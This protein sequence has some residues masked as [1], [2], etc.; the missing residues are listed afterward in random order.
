MEFKRLE[1]SVD[2]ASK[3][4]I[5]TIVGKANTRKRRSTYEEFVEDALGMDIRQRMCFFSYKANAFFADVID[6]LEFLLESANVYFKDLSSGVNEVDSHFK[7]SVN[8]SSSPGRKIQT[9]FREMMDPLKDNYMSILSVTTWESVLE[10]WRDHLNVLTSNNNFTKCSG[11]FA[12]LL[13][14]IWR[15][16]IYSKTVNE[17]SRLS[18]NYKR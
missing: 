10:K 14:I 9:S 4:I 7:D 17:H 18:R 5:Q 11:L 16:S 13:L 8:K 1:Y 2:S 3:L 12:L 6:S 15:N